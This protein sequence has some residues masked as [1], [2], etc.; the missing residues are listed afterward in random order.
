L[1]ERQLAHR[2]GSS[3]AGAYDRSQRLPERRQL[4]QDYSDLLDKLR[5]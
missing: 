3:T 1:V 4:M 5:D 2:V